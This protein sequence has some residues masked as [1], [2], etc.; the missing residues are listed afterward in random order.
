MAR[1]PAGRE[2]VRRARNVKFLYAGRPTPRKSY[3]RR[4]PAVT[5]M[6]MSQVRRS[7]NRAERLLRSLLWKAGYRFRVQAID[8]FGRPDIVFPRLRVAIF[9]DGD[10]WHGR[11]L[12]E[13]GE[14]ALR[15][16]VRGERY[17]WWRDKF[18]RNIARDTE[19]SSSL[20][21]SGWRV[22]RVWESEVL[23]NPTSIANRI[24]RIL[25]RRKRQA[26]R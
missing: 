14:I 2:L 22:V 17:P 12:R 7:D 1:E 18:R 21:K 4:D 25:D 19:V 3:V 16:V 11:V 6:M 13:G 24:A 26:A 20:K 8:V 23:R 9:V 5:S 10:F 15:A